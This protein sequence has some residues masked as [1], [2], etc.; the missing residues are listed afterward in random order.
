VPNA[1]SQIMA[2]V[3][4]RKTIARRPEWT[5]T[6]PGLHHAFLFSANNMARPRITER[7]DK[8]EKA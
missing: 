6:S 7:R 8:D 3:R 2:D 1:K 5:E 4:L